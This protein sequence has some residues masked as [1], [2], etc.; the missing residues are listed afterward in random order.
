[1]HKHTHTH[2]HI[3]IHTYNCTRKIA[4]ILTFLGTHNAHTHTH[5][6]TCTRYRVQKTQAHS[7][8]IHSNVP[9]GSDGVLDRA[10][11]QMMGGTLTSKQ[12]KEQ[13]GPG[14]G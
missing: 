11:R 14:S 12:H 3:H 4:H 10:L 9:D 8:V 5:T 6:H 2:T 1:M 13:V 7:G